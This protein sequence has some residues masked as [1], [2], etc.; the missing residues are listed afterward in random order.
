MELHDGLAALSAGTSGGAG[1]DAGGVT[2]QHSCRRRTVLPAERLDAV[3]DMLAG[4]MSVSQVARITGISRATLY[5]H[6]VA[7]QSPPR[8][9]G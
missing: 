8:V 4:G 7:T 1:G 6:Q 9:H 5:R 3:R 2:G